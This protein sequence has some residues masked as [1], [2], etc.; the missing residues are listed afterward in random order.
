MTIAKSNIILFENQLLKTQKC[1]NKDFKNIF[2]FKIFYFKMFQII[3]NSRNRR[4]CIVST[5]TKHGD[6][7]NNYFF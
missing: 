7:I 5:D 4:W 3:K 6:D 1:L 2:Y